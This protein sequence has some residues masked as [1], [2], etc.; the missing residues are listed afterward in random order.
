[1][2]E[3]KMHGDEKAVKSILAGIAHLEK[4]VPKACAAAINSTLISVRKEAVNIAREAYT[5]QAADLN[6][7]AKVFRAKA[8]LL[9]GRITFSGKRGLSLINFQ[10]R[11]NKPGGARPPEG[12]SVK[13]L[14]G[15][16][17]KHP[18]LHGQKAFVATGKNS[19]TLLFVRLKRG[20]GGLKALYGPHP[21]LAMGR[22]DS[23]VWLEQVVNRELP[24]N[25]AKAVDA[26]LAA[27]VK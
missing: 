8:G 12:A 11:P 25:L 4:G 7:K 13:V 18:R 10:A 27:S 19:N 3:I 17:R 6:R 26:V 9:S 1:M 22:D 23:G 24:V 2:I 14:R 5:V 16:S 21:I 15:G 20:R